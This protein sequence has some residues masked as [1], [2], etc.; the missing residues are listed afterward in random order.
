MNFLFYSISVCTD[1]KLWE[2]MTK[3]FFDL[4]DD[5]K[6]ELP[7]LPFFIK[8]RKTGVDAADSPEELE[9]FTVMTAGTVWRNS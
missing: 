1:S 9:Q 6:Y 4:K 8:K 3:A 2:L 7:D 5:K